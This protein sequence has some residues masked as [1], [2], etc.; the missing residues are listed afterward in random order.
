[1]K[2]AS[3]RPAAR[4]AVNS[5][6]KVQVFDRAL[7]ILDLLALE[8]P[9]LTTMQLS[10]RLKLHRS[11]TH[12]LLMVLLQHHLVARDPSGTAFRLGLKLCELGS[13][14]AAQLDL[15]ENVRP[16]L[17]RLVL[18]TGET[19]HVGVM[20]D[21]EVVSVSSVVSLRAVRTP[22]TVGKRN[23]THCTAL[24]KAML[25]FMPGEIDRLVGKEL[26][27]RTAKTITSLRAL[28]ADLNRVR[29]NGWAID[30]EEFE[31]GLRCLGAPLFNY[32]GEVVAAI[33]ITGPAFRITTEKIPALLKSL[34]REAAALSQELGYTGLLREPKA[35]A[36]Y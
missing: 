27:S 20:D 33:S 12:R 14:A 7:D 18:E 2:T 35:L 15:G 6:Y 21:G 16:H 8:G 22:S 4:A 17:K 31:E 28:K 11:T 34:L 3:P 1:M 24:G 32:Q 13:K 9:N 23:P 19:A 10:Q 25:A 30:D 5:I 29:Q 36:H 26:V